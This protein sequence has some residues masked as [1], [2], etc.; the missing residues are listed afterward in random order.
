MTADRLWAEL[1]DLDRRRFER[2]AIRPD[3]L[4]DARS[5]GDTTLIAS[6]LLVIAG[7]HLMD[8]DFYRFE[9]AMAELE[10]ML[11]ADPSLVNRLE[12]GLPRL[13]NRR[14]MLV[15][16][17]GYGVEE[18]YHTVDAFVAISGEDLSADHLRLVVNMMYHEYERG[19]VERSGQFDRLLAMWPAASADARVPREVVASC[20]SVME[21]NPAAAVEHARTAARHARHIGQYNRFKAQVTLVDAFLAANLLDDAQSALDGLAPIPTPAFHAGFSLVLGAEVARRRGEHDTATELLQNL[22]DTVDLRYGGEVRYRAV[23]A[24]ACLAVDRGDMP[25]A[26]ELA[27][28]LMADDTDMSAYAWGVRSGL[29]ASRSVGDF[30]SELEF[31]RRATALMRRA[32]RWRPHESVELRLDRAVDQVMQ[33]LRADDGEDRRTTSQRLRHD[34]MSVVGSIRLHL[35]LLDDDSNTLG[36][37]PI[38]PGLALLSE[39]ADQLSA[40]SALRDGMVLPAP[41]HVDVSELVDELVELNRQEARSRELT[42]RCSTSYGPPPISVTDRRLLTRVLN[43]LIRNSVRYTAPGGVVEV[44]VD[45]SGQRRRDYPT[46]EVDVSD[47]GPGLSDVVRWRLTRT[48]TSALSPVKGEGGLGLLIV[49]RI[50]R[51]IDLRVS[52]TESELGGTRVSV[53]IPVGAVS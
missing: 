35:D 45:P 36:L 30:A 26:L 12:P 32:P 41:T 53:V 47:S 10:S 27:H 34:L 14:A 48:G 49:R 39:M 8:D 52:V 29:A 33:R 31:A 24:A 37:S 28:E 21:G 16:K 51:L 3:L 5:V 7:G 6:A 50:S 42:I 20:R 1:R 15:G 43:N 18:W 25:R 9:H 22:D 19:C 11:A 46:V 38:R 17:R 4:A 40:F 2:P 13:A 44:T 23:A